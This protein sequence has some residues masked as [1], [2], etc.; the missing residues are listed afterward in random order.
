[1]PIS[2]CRDA[3]AARHRHELAEFLASST[4]PSPRL[5]GLS[6][7]S[8]SDVT[9]IT[10]AQVLSDLTKDPVPPTPPPS[11]LRGRSPRSGRPVT[12]LTDFQILSALT[13]D[14]SPLTLPLPETAGIVPATGDAKQRLLRSFRFYRF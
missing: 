1:M 8:R 11:K 13:N 5:R 9:T 2:D 14:P 3:V 12:T 4:R 7:Q 6:P 10:D